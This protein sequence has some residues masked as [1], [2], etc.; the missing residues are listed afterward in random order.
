[1]LLDRRKKEKEKKNKKKQIAAA[2]QS[3]RMHITNKQTQKWKS[4]IN[5]CEHLN[6]LKP[7]PTHNHRSL[8]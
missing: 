1:M 7:D 5:L 2:V 3:A 4:E 8:F 6:S